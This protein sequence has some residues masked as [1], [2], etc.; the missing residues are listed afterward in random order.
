MK[1]GVIDIGSNSVRLMMNENG[2]T[3]YK[4]IS[5]TR[6]AQAKDENGDINFIAAKPTIEAV[7]RYVKKARA[8][9]ADK[10][11][12]FATAAVRLSDNGEEFCLRVKSEAGI[13]VEILSGESEA[14]AGYVGA[15]DKKD[16]GVIDIGGASTE[17]AVVKNGE[18][19]YGKSVDIGAVTLT[20]KALN[21]E[22]VATAKAKEKIL[23][24]GDV[25]RSDFYCIGGTATSAAAMLLGLSVY[26]PNKTHG[27]KIEYKNLV[28]LKK[29]LYSMTSEERKKINGLQPERADIIQSGICILCEL[30]DYLKVDKFTVSERDNLE[31]FLALKTEKL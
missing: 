25:P 20:R 16:G 29:R 9:N 30:A 26:D 1:Y 17:I 7:S 15:L 13:D 28:A 22:L 10:I 24:F 21:D 23:A 3:L 14:R 31:G 8:E 11:Y 19:I 5:T 12:A 27:Y 4:D 18:R 6:L 2:Q